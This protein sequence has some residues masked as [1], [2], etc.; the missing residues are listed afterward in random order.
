MVTMNRENRHV[1]IHVRIGVIHDRKTE[2]KERIML[3]MG[4]HTYEVHKKIDI[5][6]WVQIC[7]VIPYG[8][9]FSILYRSYVA[10]VIKVWGGV[11]I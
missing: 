10:T 4:F 11:A 8:V 1:D 5:K 3:I 6:F 7:Y 9:F 2:S